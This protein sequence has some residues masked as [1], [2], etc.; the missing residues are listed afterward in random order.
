MALPKSNRTP[1]QIS[2]G[3]FKDGGHVWV[4]IEASSSRWYRCLN[5]GY[6]ATTYLK[7]GKLNFF[8]EKLDWTC[9]RMREVRDTHD[10]QWDNEHSPHISGHYGVKCS[11]CGTEGSVIDKIKLA[12]YPDSFIIPFRY[13]TCAQELMELALE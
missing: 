6:R 5:C 2:A 1:P 7:E 11:Q 8:V 12:N 9:Q 3:P 13:F 10:W 4:C